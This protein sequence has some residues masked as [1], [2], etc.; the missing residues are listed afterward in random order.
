MALG[1]IAIVVCSVFIGQ[2]DGHWDQT[3]GIGPI[4]DT[5]YKKTQ[6]CSRAG[7]YN[8]GGY[9]GSVQLMILHNIDKMPPNLLS[10]C[11]INHGGDDDNDTTSYEDPPGCDMEEL[12]KYKK[13]KYWREYVVSAS[14]KSKCKDKMDKWIDNHTQSSYWLAGECSKKAKS[15]EVVL[16]LILAFGILALLIGCCNFYSSTRRDGDFE[17]DPTGKEYR[18]WLWNLQYGCCR[19]GGDGTGTGY[20]MKPSPPNG[21][22][23]EHGTT[24]APF[25]TF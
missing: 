25:D 11:S 1:V 9:Y 19:K 23:R 13:C 14:S 21:V 7:C 20:Q 2:K 15:T 18:S 10:N 22:G 17:F 6:T 16:G 24:G 4:S 12:H 3:S 5:K 8:N